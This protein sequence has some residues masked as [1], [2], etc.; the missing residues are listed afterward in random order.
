MERHIIAEHPN[1]FNIVTSD[2]PD[3]SEQKEDYPDRIKTT[4]NMRAKEEFQSDDNSMDSGEDYESEVWKKLELV[5][6]E[7]E[8]CSEMNLM[9]LLDDHNKIEKQPSTRKE[10][11]RKKSKT[12]DLNRQERKFSCPEC[13]ETFVSSFYLRTHQQKIHDGQAYEC[14]VCHK[15]FSNFYKR[16]RHYKQVHS[17]KK[18][19]CPFCDKTFA[20]H[21]KLNSHLQDSHKRDSYPCGLCGESFSDCRSQTRHY[22]DV[23]VVEMLKCPA[24]PNESFKSPY[25]LKRHFERK[26]IPKVKTVPCEFC[27]KLFVD[28]YSRNR[29]AVGI[30]G[31]NMNA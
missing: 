17:E 27:E 8:K 3:S 28:L 18:L 24:C 30:H 26:H 25:F 9:K 14:K 10:E 12:L 11:N 6:V 21:N 4:E 7:G 16:N 15:S 20:L 1:I 5:M 19:Q 31:R 13:D 29:H 2:H 22:K 23:H